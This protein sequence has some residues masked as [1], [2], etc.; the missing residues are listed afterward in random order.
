MRFATLI[1]VSGWWTYAGWINADWPTSSG[2]PLWIFLVC[3]VCVSVYVTRIIGCSSDAVAFDR[4]W[5]AYDIHRLALWRTLSSTLPLLLFALGV[6]GFRERNPVAILWLLIAGLIALLALARL[7]WVEGIRFRPVKSGDFYKRAFVLAKRM[8]VSLR[9]VAVVPFG[10]GHLTNAYSRS[11]EIA[12]TDDYGHW[13]SRSR[14]DFVVGHELAH[15]K[16]KHGR[17]KQ[18]ITIAVFLAVS[19]SAF[20]FPHISGSWHLFFNIGVILAPVLILESVSRRFEYEADRE[21]VE[22][23]GDLIAATQSLVDLY[24]RAQLPVEMGMMQRLL[25]SHPGL[26]QRIDAINCAG[27]VSADELAHAPAHVGKLTA[28]P[29]R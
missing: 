24:G 10:K 5:T 14:L 26:W 4:K 11:D 20:A 12:I 15:A 21:A 17:K 18:L 22:L 28:A 6:D 9:T 19:L 8:G 3:P 16:K 1:V 2:V 27:T 13:L 7:R 29:E 25:S 23:T